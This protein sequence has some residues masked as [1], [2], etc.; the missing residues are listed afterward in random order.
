ML[1]AFVPL[2]SHL[3][4]LCLDRKE[5]ADQCRHG[6]DSP[7]LLLFRCAHL[8]VKVLGPSFNRSFLIDVSVP[9]VLGPGTSGSLRLFRIG[10]QVNTGIAYVLW[11][12]CRVVLSPWLQ[13]VD[14]CR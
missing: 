8:V 14:W 6:S 2:F 3:A 4:C 1:A 9:I 7:D 10:L 5:Y 11:P 13:P 12:A